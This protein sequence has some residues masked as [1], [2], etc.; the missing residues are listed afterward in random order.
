MGAAV[1]AV[2]AILARGGD[3]AAQ[4]A[5]V[6]GVDQR[7]NRRAVARRGSVELTQ[8]PTAPGGEPTAILPALTASTPCRPGRPGWRSC[9]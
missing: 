2:L 7:R 4:T 5:Q 6:A 1:G 3:A 8:P 9:W